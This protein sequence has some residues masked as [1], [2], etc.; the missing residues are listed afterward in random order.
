MGMNLMAAI[1]TVIILA[2]ALLGILR[3]FGLL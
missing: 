3:G 2:I 1:G